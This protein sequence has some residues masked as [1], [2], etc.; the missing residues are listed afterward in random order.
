MET[1]WIF[2]HICTN[3]VLHPQQ[4][5]DL[6]YHLYYDFVPPLWTFLGNHGNKYVA[7]HTYAIPLP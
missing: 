7:G 3:E 1:W 6:V 4:A 2:A 5:L